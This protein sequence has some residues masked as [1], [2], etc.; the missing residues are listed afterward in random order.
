VEVTVCQFGGTYPYC[1]DE[2]NPPPPGECTSYSTY[3]CGGG[4][5]GYGGGGDGGGAGDGGDGGDGSTLITDND[6]PI[7]QV[8]DC[9]KPQQTNWA[10]AFCRALEPTS[11]NLRR[12]LSALNKLTQRGGECAAIATFGRD[13]LQS[14]H[15]LR[16]FVPETGD[17]G[18]WGDPDIGVLLALTWVENFGNEDN[19]NYNVFLSVLTHEVEHAMGRAHLVDAQGYERNETPNSEACSS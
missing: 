5:G 11:E 3:R 7:E 1:W 8:P 15:L 13:L 10:R 18:G 16:Y 19:A 9:T 17:A 6:V 2:P 4:G 12:T 14:R